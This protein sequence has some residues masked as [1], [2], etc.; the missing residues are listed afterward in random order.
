MMNHRI[1]DKFRSVPQILAVTAMP[2]RSFCPSLWRD[3]L[4]CALILNMIRDSWDWIDFPQ[5]IG[6]CRIRDFII[7]LTSILWLSRTRVHWGFVW[8]T[9]RVLT[10][11]YQK[12]REFRYISWSCL[13]LEGATIY[14]SYS[15]YYYFSNG[16]VC[17]VVVL[18][19]VQFFQE[20]FQIFLTEIRSRQ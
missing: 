4:R 1:V 13:K 19:F 6:S 18:N 16:F 11:A 2:D 3:R 10:R 20:A 14:F 5:G 15:Y 7:T 17:C 12:V 9:S 8:W